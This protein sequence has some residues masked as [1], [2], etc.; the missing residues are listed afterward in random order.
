M[1][2]RQVV[3]LWILAIL[4]AAAAFFVRS[5]NSKGFESN[6]QRARGATLLADFPATEVAK[7]QVNSGDNSSTLVRKDGKWTVAERENYPANTTTI[8]QRT[9]EKQVCVEIAN[10]I[11]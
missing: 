7:I 1:S 9:V 11:K 6:T 3:V 4:L 10:K 5:G 2:K 8:N